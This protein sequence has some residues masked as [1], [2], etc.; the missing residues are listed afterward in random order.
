MNYDYTLKL[1]TPNNMIDIYVFLWIIIKGNACQP[2]LS[3]GM[4]LFKA[5]YSEI[6]LDLKIMVTADLT[7]AVSEV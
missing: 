3:P 5:F 1:F 6:K 7:A 4:F 2:N